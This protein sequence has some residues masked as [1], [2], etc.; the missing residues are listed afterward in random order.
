MNKKKEKDRIKF[1]YSSH[2]IND[3][4]RCRAFNEKDLGVSRLVFIN[5]DEYV[6]EEAVNKLA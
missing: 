6:G 1:R 2:L 4:I 5:F 3:W